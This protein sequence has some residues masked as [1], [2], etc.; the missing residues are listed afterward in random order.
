M[1]RHIQGNA[2]THTRVENRASGVTPRAATN[3][4][5]IGNLFPFPFNETNK[6]TKTKWITWDGLSPVI[7]CDGFLQTPRT[8][9][10]EKRCITRCIPPF[11]GAA[12]LQSFRRAPLGR[13]CAI[14]APL[15]RRARIEAAAPQ[16]LHRC[17]HNVLQMCA[18]LLQLQHHY[19]T[20]CAPTHL[21][22]LTPTDPTPHRR[23]EKRPSPAALHGAAP[24]MGS[25]VARQRAAVLP[26]RGTEMLDRQTP[27]D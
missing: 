23:A 9:R 8:L 14:A 15:L 25:H 27:T 1:R 11:R 20:G 6:K 3:S 16:V 24:P 13:P 21:G 26:Q 19:T 2:P 22:A 12:K 5:E 18:Q 10:R 7:D 17:Q 4:L